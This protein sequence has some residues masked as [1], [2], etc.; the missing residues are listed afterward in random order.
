MTDRPLVPAPLARGARGAV[1]APHHLATQAGLAVLAAGGSAVDAAIA[2]NAVLAVVMPSGCG[3]GGDAFWLVWD[4]AERRLSG[5]NGSGC[6][7]AGADARRLRERGLS[8]VPRRGGLSIT[9]P[10]AVR[11]WSD[12]HASW[13]RLSASAIL[14]EAIELAD[15]GFPAWDGFIGA[16]EWTAPIALEV[17]PADGFGQVYRPHGRPWRPGERVRLPALASTLRRLADEGFDTLYDGDL[18]E[19]QAATLARVGAP[20]TADDFARHRTERTEPISAGYRDVTVATHPPNSSGVV[21]LE[22]LRLLDTFDPPPALAFGPTGWTDDR[23]VHLGIEAAKLALV[24]RDDLICDPRDHPVDVEA[25]LGADHIAALASRIDPLRAAVD[26]DD[27]RTLVSGTI[28]LAVVDAEGAAVSLIQSNA[29]GFGSGIVDAR[30]GIPYHDRGASFSL[31]EGHHNEL[32]GGRRPLHSLLPAMTFRGPDLSGGPWIV[33]GSMGGDSQPQ[34][35]AQVVS[36]IVDGA[37]DVASAV[38]A[39]RWSVGAGADVGP[40]TNVLIEPRFD[41]RVID[42]LEARGHP[43]GHAADFDGALGHAHAIELV[44]G[45][46]AAGGSL[47]A[48]TDPRSAGLPAVR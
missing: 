29:A 22:I 32:Q 24:D 11:S 15:A 36:A 40:P 28:Y 38:A 5:L 43:L 4:A 3:I 1:V 17:D 30:T 31:E 39:P 21:G 48:A 25:I 2:T 9:V 8:S 33:H 18:A 14:A 19:Q 23:W 7:P 20:F 27:V 46:P 16:V 13:G 35:L 37:A 10:G 45:G 6:A 26:L 12:A 34:I 44:D 42:G 47:A 41:P